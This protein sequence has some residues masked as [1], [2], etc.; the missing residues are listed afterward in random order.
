MIVQPDQGLTK[1]PIPILRTKKTNKKCMKCTIDG[2]TYLTFTK[3]TIVGDSATLCH[4]FGDDEGIEDAVF[5]DEKVV[6]VGNSKVHV[7]LKG[8]KRCRFKQTDG[9]IV[10]RVLYPAKVARGLKE[11]LFPSHVS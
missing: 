1:V 4:L 6:G 9:T 10:E 3:N 11:P 7:T 8:K 2:R 5:I